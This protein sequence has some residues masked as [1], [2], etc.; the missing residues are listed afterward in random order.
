M[1]KKSQSFKQQFKLNVSSKASPKCTFPP[2]NSLKTT[3]SQKKFERK[4]KYKNQKLIKQEKRSLE[5]CLNL[6]MFWYYH[7]K[8]KKKCKF[9][10]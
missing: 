5:V 6:L 4:I 7:K 2:L 10:L 9:H 1:K 3:Q 8:D